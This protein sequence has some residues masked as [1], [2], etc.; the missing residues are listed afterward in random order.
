M[1][2]NTQGAQ[3][4]HR[5]QGKEQ[6]LCH[7][8]VRMDG[9]DRDRMAE[10]LVCLM[11]AVAPLLIKGLQLFVNKCSLNLCMSLPIIPSTGPCKHLTKM[12]FLHPVPG[13]RKWITFIFLLTVWS[14][15]MVL[16]ICS[17]FKLVTFKCNLKSWNTL[18][19]GCNYFTF[20]VWDKK[21]SPT[22]SLLEGCQN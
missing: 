20:I 5:T 14:N 8:Q 13:S 19:A 4:L 22:E 21:S 1:P 6:L 16:A 2:Q 7:L 9:Q 11:L 12:C 3:A 10:E 17:K 18:L 15:F